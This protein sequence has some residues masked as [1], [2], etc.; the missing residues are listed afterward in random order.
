MRLRSG[1]SAE[2]PQPV[3]QTCISQ[4][5][6]ES[7]FGDPE[8]VEKSLAQKLGESGNHRM[9]SAGFLWRVSLHAVDAIKNAFHGLRCHLSPYMSLKLCLV[10]DSIPSANTTLFNDLPSTKPTRKHCTEVL[11]K[12]ELARMGSKRTAHLQHTGMG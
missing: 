4:P 2:F 3:P 12:R 5:G 7:G 9:R 8:H 1:P 6:K 10:V 11:K